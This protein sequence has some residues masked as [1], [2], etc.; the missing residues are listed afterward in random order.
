MEI[1]L[2]QDCAG[3]FLSPNGAAPMDPTHCGVGTLH[4]GVLP[5]APLL[6]ALWPQVVVLERA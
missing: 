1:R 4:K 3:A 2:S 5:A 6:P